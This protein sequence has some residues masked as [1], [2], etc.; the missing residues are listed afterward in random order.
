MGHYILQ[1][2]ADIIAYS[3][4]NTGLVQLFFFDK[5]GSGKWWFTKTSPKLAFVSVQD[6]SMSSALAIE[7]L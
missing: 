7:M 4:L 6:G 5:M 2:N 3:C 1:F